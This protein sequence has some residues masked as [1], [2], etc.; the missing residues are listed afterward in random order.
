MAGLILR[1][2]RRQQPQ[3]AVPV[4]SVFGM[5]IGTVLLGSVQQA[6]NGGALTKAGSIP[7]I[8]TPVGRAWEGNTTGSRIVYAT[9]RRPFVLGTD[10]DVSFVIVFRKQNTAVDA[11]TIAGFGAAT[12]AAGNTLFRLVGGGTASRIQFQVQDG[13]AIV[14]YNTQ[15]DGATA[16]ND[17][18]WH[19]AVISMGLRAGDTLDYTIDGRPNG[20]V[21]RAAGTPSATTF[22]YVAACGA[23]RG[24]APLGY[25]NYDVALVA[26]I[27]GRLSAAQ[28]RALSLNPWQLFKAPARRIWVSAGAPAGTAVDPAVGTI[29]LT[30]YAP[31]VAQSTNQSVTPGAGSLVITGYAPTVAQPQA[32]NPDAGSLVIT[33]YAPTVT[34]ASASQNILPGVGSLTIT[35]YAPSVAQSS[36]SSMRPKPRAF[37]R[38]RIKQPEEYENYQLEAPVV[39]QPPKPVQI[40]LEPEPVDFAKVAADTREALQ[41]ALRKELRQAV[42]SYQAELEHTRQAQQEEERLIELKRQ[43]DEDEEAIEMLLLM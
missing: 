19:T 33:G 21:A 13:T 23:L 8:S 2:P 4:D 6:L 30:G 34:Q 41:Q 32:V 5:P 39:A 10:L 35:G 29:A 7:T 14:Y 25:G 26:P 37:S 24:N 43:I 16:V 17:L 27:F 1:H 38:W 15:S 36:S 9:A 28:A 20:T 12:G 22:P 42:L 31:T 11:N 18:A 40:I 3:Q